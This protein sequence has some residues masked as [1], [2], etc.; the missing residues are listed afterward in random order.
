MKKEVMRLWMR[1]GV[2]LMPTAEEAK[3][4]LSEDAGAAKA[5]VERLLENGRFRFQGNS[6]IPSSEVE[7][8]YR[9][10]GVIPK[11]DG[12]LEPEFEL[13]VTGGAAAVGAERLEWHQAPSLE[14][15]RKAQMCLRDNGVPVEETASVL[16][17]L[18]YIFFDAETADQLQ[19]DGAEKNAPDPCGL[20]LHDCEAC[21]AHDGCTR[22]APPEDTCR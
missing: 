12:D 10:Y 3:K 9:E 17:A 13:D 22:Q 6:Y 19:W 7:V 5:V 2:D 4:I 1:A 18:C 8:F 16:Q 11:P 21:P 14:M 15:I 20:G